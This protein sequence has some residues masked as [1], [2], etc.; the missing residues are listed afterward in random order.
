MLIIMGVCKWFA[1]IFR[2]L[3]H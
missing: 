1:R 3:R 2:T